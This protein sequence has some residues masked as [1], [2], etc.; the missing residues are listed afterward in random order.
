MTEKKRQFKSRNGGKTPA[1]LKD[2]RVGMKKFHWVVNRWQCMVWSSEIWVRGWVL[3][4]GRGLAV[5]ETPEQAACEVLQAVW[6]VRE[7]TAAKALTSTV[8]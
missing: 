3:R 6:A 8:K 5:P 7:V 2:P 4:A 1:L